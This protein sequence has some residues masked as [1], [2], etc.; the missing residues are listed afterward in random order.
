MP[1]TNHITVIYWIYSLKT[2]KIH[3]KIEQL[4]LLL[5]SDIK[6]NYLLEMIAEFQPSPDVL[7]KINYA[8]KIFAKSGL[9]TILRYKRCL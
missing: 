7:E 1:Q 2:Y 9:S 8:A 3:L 6:I 4:F 5:S